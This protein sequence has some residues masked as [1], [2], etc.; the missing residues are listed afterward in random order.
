MQKVSPAFTVALGQIP[1]IFLFSFLSNEDIHNQVGK[2]IHPVDISQPICLVTHSSHG[3]M[4]KSGH[5]SRDDHA[6]AQQHGFSTYQGQL[7]AFTAE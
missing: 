6:L 4:K 5:N 7:A 1:K 2:M 3:L